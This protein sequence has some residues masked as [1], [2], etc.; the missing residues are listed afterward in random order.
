MR[1]ADA[2]HWTSLVRP[3][4]GNF[5]LS[6]R[7][8]RAISAVLA[9][10]LELALIFMWIKQTHIDSPWA[11]SGIPDAVYDIQYIP[12][13]G[14]QQ[15][16]SKAP[17]KPAV[18]KE[19]APTITPNAD[20]ITLWVPPKEPVAPPPKPEPMPEPRTLSQDQAEEFKRQWAQMQGELQ[21]EAVD[22]V[23]HVKLAVDGE[24]QAKERHSEM[25]Q[26]REREKPLQTVLQEHGQKTDRENRLDALDGSILAG[27][28]CVT[29]GRGDADMQVALPC[30]GDNYITDYSWYTR[31]RAPQRGEINT[32]PI[33]PNGRVSV[34]RYTFKPATQAAFEDATEQLHKIQVTIRM[35]YLP[36]LRMPLQLLSRDDSVGAIGA[37]AFASEEELAAYLQTWA[38]NVRRWTAPRN[39]AP[40]PSDAAPVPP[41]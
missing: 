14:T 12:V 19:P 18:P 28:L 41:R 38:D 3:L 13:D 4:R 2:A 15:R 32:R 17:A 23:N 37:E 35:V 29:G 10:A 31:V 22:K 8:E 9:A 1:G 6:G 30:V 40:A 27:E 26:L 39:G 36:E 20:T 33:D 25:A 5:A 21:K 24:Q 34:R 11:R 7:R 16:I